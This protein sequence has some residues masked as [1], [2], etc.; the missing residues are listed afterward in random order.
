M[1]KTYAKKKEKYQLIVKEIDQHQFHQTSSIP[2]P[3]P[4]DVGSHLSLVSLLLS[5]DRYL[6]IPMRSHSDCC[7]VTNHQMLQ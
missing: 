6:V 3:Q 5:S 4:L 2:K 1:Y 7:F